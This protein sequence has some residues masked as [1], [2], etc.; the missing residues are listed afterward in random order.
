[1]MLAVIAAVA[2]I[3]ESEGRKVKNLQRQLPNTLAAVH[4]T[5]DSVTSCSITALS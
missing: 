3:M 5:L 1:M 2:A 4:A